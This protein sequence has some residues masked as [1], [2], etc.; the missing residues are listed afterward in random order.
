MIFPGHSVQLPI[1][2]ANLYHVTALVGRS[3]LFSFFTT[4]VP[5]FLGTTYIGLTHELSDIR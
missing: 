3:S 4:I 5:P 2:D 1:V